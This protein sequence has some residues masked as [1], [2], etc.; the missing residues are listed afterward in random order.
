MNIDRLVFTLAGT[1][2][3]ASVILGAFVS[4]WFLLIAAFVGTNL[5]Q[6]SITG[7]CPAAAI[8]KRLGVPSGCAFN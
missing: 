5:L 3:L 2:T 4:P 6:A 8:L 7:I 1:L